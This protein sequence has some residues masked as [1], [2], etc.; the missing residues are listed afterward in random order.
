MIESITFTK[1]V[2]I[3]FGNQISILNYNL[4]HI[5]S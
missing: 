1:S 2:I 5:N 3:E 4:L